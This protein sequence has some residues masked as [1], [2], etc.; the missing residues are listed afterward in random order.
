MQTRVI[1]LSGVLVFSLVT[2]AGATMKPAPIANV[3]SAVVKVA[4]GCGA[5]RWRGPGGHCHPLAV[6]RLCPKGYHI[7]PEGRRCWPD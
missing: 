4:E 2:A 5:G 6:N 3:D 1:C 7:G